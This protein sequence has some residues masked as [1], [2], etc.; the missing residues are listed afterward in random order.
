[1]LGTGVRTGRALAV[2]WAE[3]D[4]ATGT[5]TIQDHR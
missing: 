5:A 2:S 3:I 1:M 4:L